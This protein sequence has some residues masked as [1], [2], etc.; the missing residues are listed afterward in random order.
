MHEK[1]PENA[2]EVMTAYR[3]IWLILLWVFILLWISP[4]ASFAAVQPLSGTAN[5]S[6]SLPAFNPSLADGNR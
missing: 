4:L 2:P 3:L 5:P 6:A 1:R